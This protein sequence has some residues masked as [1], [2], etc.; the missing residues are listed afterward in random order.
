VKKFPL[1]VLK[2]RGAL[3]ARFS[4]KIVRFSIN[5]QGNMANNRPSRTTPCQNTLIGQKNTKVFC[6]Q[7]GD[8]TDWTVWNWSGETFSPRAFPFALDFFSPVPTFACPTIP[9]WVSED[10]KPTAAQ[11]VGGGEEKTEI[12]YQ[13]GNE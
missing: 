13:Q 4:L 2:L 6:A 3:T 12:P 8:R 5:K 11:K 1:R 7:S 9:P 10:G